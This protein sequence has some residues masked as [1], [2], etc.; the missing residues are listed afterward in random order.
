MKGS[1]WTGFWLVI[2]QIYCC[3]MTGMLSETGICTHQRPLSIL[4]WILDSL[5]KTSTLPLP[6]LLAS[7]VGAG[8]RTIFCLKVEW[9][10]HFSQVVGAYHGECRVRICLFSFSICPYFCFPWAWLVLTCSIKR[11]QFKKGLN[12]SVVSAWKSKQIHNAEIRIDLEIKL[13]LG[14]SV[15]ILIICW[16]SRM[17]LLLLYWFWFVLFFKKNSHHLIDYNSGKIHQRAFTKYSPVYCLLIC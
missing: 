15:G 5:W 1:V 8:Y 11:N 7:S 4:F 12:F 6:F 17:V 10:N 3:S 9:I 16:D 14:F 2:F 13:I